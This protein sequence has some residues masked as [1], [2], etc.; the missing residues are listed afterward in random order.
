MCTDALSASIG[1]LPLHREGHSA[2]RLFRDL[3]RYNACANLCPYRT[4]GRLSEREYPRDRLS[5][6]GSLHVA[7]DHPSVDR[8]WLA[9]IEGRS[10]RCFDL[11]QILYTDFDRPQDRLRGRRGT[12]RILV[13]GPFKQGSIRRRFTAIGE[14]TDSKR[15]YAWC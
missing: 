13:A 11:E 14:A 4:C 12:L 9:R 5:A 15:S 2:Q 8:L 1:K 6:F 3:R 7:V 10:P